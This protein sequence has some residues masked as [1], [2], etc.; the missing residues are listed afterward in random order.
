MNI[1]SIKLSEKLNSNILTNYELLSE[2]GLLQYIEVLNHTIVDQ[3]ELLNEAVEIFNKK[4]VVELVNYITTKFLNKFVPETLTFIIQDEVNP[5]TVNIMKFM[6]LQPVESKLKIDNFNIYKD[7]FVLSP[8]SIT[9]EAFEVMMDSEKDTVLFESLNPELLVPIMGLDGV[10]GF[11]IFGKKLACQPF[12]SDEIVFIDEIMKFV[13]ISLQN[14]IHYKR[15]ITDLKTRLYN[16]DYFMQSLIRELARLKRHGTEFGVLI[17]DIDHFK[18]VNDTYGH[19]AGDKIIKLVADTVRQAIRTDDIAARFGGEEF[20]VLLT[21]CEYEFVMEVAERIRTKIEKY[22]IIYNNERVKL[23]ISIGG[24]HIT[25][26]TID[27]PENILKKID[28]ALYY[29]KE[30]GRNRSKLYTE[31]LE[32]P[33][34]GV[35]E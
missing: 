4:S 13:S 22:K 11:I 34:G 24:I 12:E 26:N 15:A 30:H 23:S 1:G 16:H 9:F 6:N 5:D 35:S 7:F 10:Y 3:N 2:T 8:T 20:V 33:Q 21:A 25:R 17:M 29:C 32:N 31:N 18:K 19:V 28:K 27:L 14:I